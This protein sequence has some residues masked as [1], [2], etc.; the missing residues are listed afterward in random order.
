MY[1]YPGSKA[2]G[3]FLHYVFDVPRRRED[4]KY[5]D[6]VLK[7]LEARGYDL[8]TLRFSICKKG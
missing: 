6:P 8:T 4:D 3:H 2:D 7:Q 5:D 1:S